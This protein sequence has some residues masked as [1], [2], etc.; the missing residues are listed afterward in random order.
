MN[1]NDFISYHKSVSAE[2]KASQN[3]VRFFI[4]NYHWGED[5]RFKEVLLMNYLKK[6]LPSNVS[7]G[8]GFVR[9]GNEVSSQIDLIIFNNSCPTLFSEGDFIIVLPESVYGIIEVKSKIRA[10]RKFAAAIKKANNN[11]KLIGSD[12][13]NGIFGYECDIAFSNEGALADTVKQALLENQG[14]INHIVFGPN[15]FMKYWKD[16]NPHE[17]N[18]VKCFSFYQLEELSIGYFVSN[19]IEYIHIKSGGLKMSDEMEN[20]LYPIEHGKESKR[21]NNLEIKLT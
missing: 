15:I 20:F 21:L 14:Y 5:G 16:G 10:E 9:K 1:N 18:K 12:I 2:L 4:N 7:V 6:V 11:G 8:T 17:D 13:F 19:L 3:R